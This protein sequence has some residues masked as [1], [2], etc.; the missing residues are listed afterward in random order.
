MTSSIKHVLCYLHDCKYIKFSKHCPLYGWDKLSPLP[1]EDIENY[2]MET[3]EK[4]ESSTKFAKFVKKLRET[5][6]GPDWRDPLWELFI[7][8]SHVLEP[9]SRLTFSWKICIHTTDI[10]MDGKD[11]NLNL[12]FF[13]RFTVDLGNISL[14]NHKTLFRILYDYAMILW[15]VLVDGSPT[16]AHRWRGY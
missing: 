15:G 12:R 4:Q 1:I 14:K 16:P 2:E 7:L 10:K 13:C 6:A 3:K 5:C 8:V 9:Q 11:D